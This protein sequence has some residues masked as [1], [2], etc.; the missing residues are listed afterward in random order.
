MSDIIVDGQ[1]R[2]AFVPT[3]AVPTAATVAELNAGTLLH[4]TLIPTGL[5]GFEPSTAEVDNTA[6][7]STFDTKLPGRGSFSGTGLVLK[8]QTATDTVFTLLS[9]FN[10]A[11]FIVIRDGVPADTAW[12]AADK[13]EAYPG[14]TGLY[15]MLGRGEA[16]SL[17]RYRVPFPIG[18]SRVQGV[19]AA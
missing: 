18:A 11:G 2:V 15:S 19:V 1:T 7:A 8:K 4:W 3:I 6:L 12:T 14:R 9:V 17:L 16:N 5:E 10:T 13:Y